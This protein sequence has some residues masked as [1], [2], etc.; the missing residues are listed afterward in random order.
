MKTYIKSATSA[1]AAGEIL[2][3][4]LTNWI[5]SGLFVDVLQLQRYP[6][7]EWSDRCKE[8]YES[9]VYASVE[10]FFT[11]NFDGWYTDNIDDVAEAVWS[12]LEADPDFNLDLEESIEELS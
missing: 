4:C 8:I 5:G 9:Q 6:R 1:H 3:E 12:K 7:Q 2:L 11:E 10:N